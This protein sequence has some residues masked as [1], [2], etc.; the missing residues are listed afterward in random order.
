MQG[1][2]AALVAFFF[3]CVVFPS[4]V[5][6]RP[7]FYA[8]LAAIV[9]IILL[10]AVAHMVSGKEPGAFAVMAYVFTAILQ[11]GAIL[12]MFMSTGGLSARELAGDMK[13]AY[14]V[15]RRGE[16][17][18]SIII[19][20]TGQTPSPKPQPDATPSIHVIDPDHPER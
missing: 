15:M 3:V 18:K 20:L 14:E 2:T 11:V 13:R 16:E 7:Q 12:L 9:L 5:K 10:D 6:N 1:V 4:L 19:P 8:A 17:Q